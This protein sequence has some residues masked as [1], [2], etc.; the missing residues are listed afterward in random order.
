MKKLLTF[1]MMAAFGLWM[2]SCDTR[3]D[4][5]YVDHDTYSIVYDLANVDLTY[6]PAD[7]LYSI[8]RTMN[9]YNSD[10]LLMYR[11]TGTTTTGQPVWQQIPR[12][13]YFNSGD[14]L[15]YDFD[16]SSQDFVI[17]AS[18]TYDLSTTP[19]YINDQTFRVVIVPAS[20]G[21]QKS[22]VDYSDY[23]SV[24]QHYNIDDS[25]PVKL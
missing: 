24:I 21:A 20:F 14:E 10:V 18:G 13:I 11:R 1:V 8:S 6:S 15:D 4:R 7:G 22:Q 17:Y 9:I 12:T 23:D 19:E 25:K 16:F 2:I 3:D 5:D